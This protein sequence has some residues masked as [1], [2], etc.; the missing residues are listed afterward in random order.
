[1]HMADDEE[2]IVQL[3]VICCNYHYYLHCVDHL[4]QRANQTLNNP[5]IEKAEKLLA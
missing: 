2:A 5:K 4:L 3:S 1:M